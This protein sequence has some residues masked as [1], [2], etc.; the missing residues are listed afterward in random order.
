MIIDTKVCKI[1]QK[2]DLL[3]AIEGSLDNLDKKMNDGLVLLAK[4]DEFEL[5]NDDLKSKI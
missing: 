4:L 1:D 3:A 2:L 5:H